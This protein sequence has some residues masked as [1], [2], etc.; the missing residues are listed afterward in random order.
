M[1]PCL[2]DEALFAKVTKIFEDDYRCFGETVFDATYVYGEEV[3]VG[4]NESSSK[5]AALAKVPKYHPAAK[6][7][8]ARGQGTAP[9]KHP[10]ALGLAPVND[11]SARVPR[12]HP[13]ANSPTARGQ[14]KASKPYAPGIHGLKPVK[15]PAVKS[16]GVQGHSKAPRKCAPGVACAPKKVPT[17]SPAAEGRSKG[18][19]PRSLATAERGGAPGAAGAFYPAATPGLAGC[20]VR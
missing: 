6:S 2:V 5:T 12:Y 1:V 10:Y 14:G 11:A 3:N 17:K 15:I 18:D 8:A 19:N 20:V 7:P 9:K 16:P 13:A 4:G